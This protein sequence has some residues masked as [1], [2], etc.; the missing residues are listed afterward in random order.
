MGKRFGFAELCRH[1]YSIKDNVLYWY[2][3]PD[4]FYIKVLSDLLVSLYTIKAK[5]QSYS[6]ILFHLSDVISTDIMHELS[7][8]L[9]RFIQFGDGH[10]LRIF[11]S[12][13]E[14]NY[15]GHAFIKYQFK[16]LLLFQV[17]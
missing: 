9:K 7:L 10:I 6:V 4:V 16:E 12:K 8:S 1:Y 15:P 3:N 11:M 14:R 2:Q 13:S 5:L 17:T